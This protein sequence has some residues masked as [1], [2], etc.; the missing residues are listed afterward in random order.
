MKKEYRNKLII[1]MLLWV[2][3]LAFVII[4]GY[5]SYDPNDPDN[6]KFSTEQVDK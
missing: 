4:D 1:T 2:A 3:I 5:M 6:V